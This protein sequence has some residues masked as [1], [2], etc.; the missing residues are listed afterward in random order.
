L[1]SEA[2]AFQRLGNA[3]TVLFT[4]K[5]I[6]LIY[7]GDEIGMPGAGDPD[8]RRMMT[9]TGYSDGQKTLLAH[10]KKL[11]A[12]RAAHPALRKGTRKSLGT[13]VDTLAYEMSFSG[14]D[15]VVLVNRADTP[16]SIGGVPA[17]TWTDQLGGGMVTGSAMVPARS[18]M[19]LTK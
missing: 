16:Q 19:I 15:V 5:G 2:S 14:D 1:P 8:N 6:P 9:W 4:N 7:Y 10:V 13:S 17:G 3:F 11:T 12:I 18:A